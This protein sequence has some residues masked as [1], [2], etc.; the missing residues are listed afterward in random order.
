MK[1]YLALLLVALF[2]AASTDVCGQSLSSIAGRTIQLTITSGSFPYAT[3]GGFRFL[4]SALDSQYAIVP[5]SVTVGPGYG[6]YSYAKTGASTGSISFNDAETGPGTV[7]CVFTSAS[8]GT[9]TLT[10]SFG[11]S[12]N[13]TFRV[14]SGASP[15]SIG[16]SSFTVTIT[17]GATPYSPTGA[18][19][20]LPAVTGNNFNVINIPSSAGGVGTFVYTQNSA[21]TGYMTY[22]DS[23]VG[24]GCI[25]QMS[26]DTATSGTFLTYRPGFSGYQT[27]TFVKGAPTAPTLFT[28][29]QSQ[30]VAAGANVTFS[31][32]AYGTG[33]FAYQWRSN[34]VAITGAT[35]GSYTIPLAQTTSAAT[36]SVMVTNNAGSNLSSGAVL[37]VTAPP[38][39]TLTGAAWSGTNGFGHGISGQ[40]GVSYRLQA[41]T[42]LTVWSDVTNLIGAGVLA[43]IRDEGATNLTRR[44]YRVV[45][46]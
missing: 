42:N 36:Y 20:F 23:L 27:G 19:Q 31:V 33:P 28:V 7:A 13:G 34:T 44:F 39:P 41:S 30:T 2:G 5:T 12:Q 40:T 6:T 35:S 11:G 29:P 38:R 4:P 3:T 37:T 25:A 22:D 46:P 45:S 43:Q 21:T 26:F 18:Y 24:S 8:S 9:Y 32:V 14:F 17:S 10:G 16:G 15:A 1:T